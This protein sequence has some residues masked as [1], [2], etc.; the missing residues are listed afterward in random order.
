MNI[1][2]L[3]SQ[4][5]FMNAD[6]QIV[7]GGKLKFCLNYLKRNIKAINIKRLHID[8]HNYKLGLKSS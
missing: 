1:I 2:M 5:R 6:S 3:Q 4:P 8:K 7:K